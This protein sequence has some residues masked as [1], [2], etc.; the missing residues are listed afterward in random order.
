MNNYIRNVTH[1][2]AIICISL[3]NSPT[4]C[5]IKILYTAAIIDKHY[6][7]RKEE[8]L[9]CIKTLQAFGYE[10]Y[11]VESIC[12]GPTFFNDYAKNICYTK[13][14]LSYIR[15]KGVN[16]SLSMQ[17]GLKIF[18]FDDND[19]IVKISGR[20]YFTSD[21]FLQYIDKHPEIDAFVKYDPHRQVFTGC[22]ALR[23]CYFRRLL[24]IIDYNKMELEMINFERIVANYIEQIKKEGAK[25]QEVTDIGLIA[26]YFGDGDTRVIAYR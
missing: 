4:F 10:P 5:S 19:M 11:I 23:A 16:E 12:H 3:L 15:N 14:N 9:Y 25:I 17:E 2:V 18:A 24:D 21:K 7:M 26:H 20:C 8:F 22:F 13:T 1:I 6:Q